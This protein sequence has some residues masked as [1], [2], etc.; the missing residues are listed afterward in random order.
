MFAI[1]E[2]KN[3]ASAL[4][5]L[6]VLVE[7]ANEENRMH[8]ICKHKVPEGVII[9]DHSHPEEEADCSRTTQAVKVLRGE[10]LGIAV[11]AQVDQLRNQGHCF[12]EHS[13][14][15]EH[16]EGQE[17]FTLGTRMED[18]R[19][20]EAACKEYVPFQVHCTNSLINGVFVREAKVHYVCM[21]NHRSCDLD[22]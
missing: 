11:L 10:A 20:D 8:E 13:K 16:L 19:K 6:I 22:H 7:E 2:S 14:G 3:G 4:L 21:K 17:I 1:C 5:R 15:D 18:H 12:H 9:A